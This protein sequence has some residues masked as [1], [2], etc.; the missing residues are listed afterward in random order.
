M[1]NQNELNIDIRFAPGVWRKV[2]WCVVA[3]NTACY[4][5]RATLNVTAERNNWVE[6]LQAYDAKLKAKRESL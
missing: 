3:A 1:E 6:R 4:I 2:F 5:A